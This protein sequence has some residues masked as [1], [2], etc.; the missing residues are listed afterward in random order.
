[1]AE[2][3]TER[4]NRE[5]YYQRLLHVNTRTPEKWKNYEMAQQTIIRQHKQK[6]DK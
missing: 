6:M 3:I 5:Q 2:S 4:K 1:M